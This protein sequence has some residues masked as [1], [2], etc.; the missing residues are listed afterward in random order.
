MTDTIFMIESI[1]LKRA[2]QRV[3]GV[4]LAGFLALDVNGDAFVIF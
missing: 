3:L 1:E 2:L 4:N